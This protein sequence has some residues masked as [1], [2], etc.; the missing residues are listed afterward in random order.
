MVYFIQGIDTII[1]CEKQ[2]TLLY[3]SNHSSI[4]TFDQCIK[5]YSSRG[6][7]YLLE[8]FFSYTCDKIQHIIVYILVGILNRQSDAFITTVGVANVIRE[9]VIA[10]SV[11][12]W[13]SLKHGF[14]SIQRAVTVV[15]ISE[16][17]VISLFLIIYTIRT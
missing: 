7:S 17:V 16:L 1:H 4:R 3:K 5:I 2:E 10:T 11:E 6:L 15:K 8:I 13:S 14:I 12:I 9:D